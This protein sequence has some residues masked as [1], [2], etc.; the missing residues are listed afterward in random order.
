MALSRKYNVELS[1]QLLEWS[2]Q[3]HTLSGVYFNITLQPTHL[4]L[5]LYTSPCPSGFRQNFGCSRS[6]YFLLHV[7]YPVNRRVTTYILIPWSRA[8]LEKL[9]G[10]QLVKKFPTFYGNL[11]YIT[12]FISARH[13]SLSWARSIKFTLPLHPTSWR[14]VLILSSHLCVLLPSRLF[15]SGFP[16][17]PLYAPF[18]SPVV[19]HDPPITFFSIW[20]PE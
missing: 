4:G 15:P 17:K 8:L 9:T 12:S 18:L 5:D 2:R 10:S 3:F 19:L 6:S 7:T 13:L 14:S 20:S 16:T 1:P 11:M